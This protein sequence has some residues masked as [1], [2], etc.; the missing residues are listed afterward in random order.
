MS[1]CRTATV[2]VH[3]DM[4]AGDAVLL[5]SRTMRRDGAN[6]AHDT[7]AWATDLRRRIV[8]RVSFAPSDRLLAGG[9]ETRRAREAG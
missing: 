6:T 3:L 7:F 2:G 8:L 5:D 1:R 9:D 4:E